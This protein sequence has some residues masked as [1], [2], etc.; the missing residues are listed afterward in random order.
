MHSALAELGTGLLARATL[1]V[2]LD[3][4]SLGLGSVGF[5]VLCFWLA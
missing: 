3:I 5:A 2:A 1:G 4:L